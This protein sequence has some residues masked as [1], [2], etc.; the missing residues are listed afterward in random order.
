MPRAGMRIV[1]LHKDGREVLYCQ[2]S[3]TNTFFICSPILQSSLYSNAVAISRLLPA[4]R[5]EPKTPI[6]I[7]PNL[8]NTPRQETSFA[9][10]SKYP[11]MPRTSMNV[12][13]T[14]DSNGNP[15][16]SFPTDALCR[17]YWEASPQF[18]SR[19]RETHSA[20]EEN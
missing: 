20:H 12:A 5:I 19:L 15:S 6:V 2:K 8:A 4:I 13:I 1:P 7:S 3:K 18:A 16:D 14:E 11:L 10:C 9:S 17:G